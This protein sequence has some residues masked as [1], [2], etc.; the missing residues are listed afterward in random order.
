MALETEYLVLIFCNG[1]LNIQYT[2]FNVYLWSLRPL[3]ED[4]ESYMNLDVYMQLVFLTLK[5]FNL[6]NLKSRS[7]SFLKSW[8]AVRNG[9]NYLFFK[10]LICLPWLIR[11]PKPFKLAILKDPNYPFRVNLPAETV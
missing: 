3:N 2:V 6:V 4:C 9:L 5:R 8:V 1:T 10:A 7:C 11:R